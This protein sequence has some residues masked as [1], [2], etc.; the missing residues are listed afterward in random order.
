MK[1]YQYKPPYGVFVCTLF[2]L[3]LGI[4]TV[5][6]TA[7]TVR[8]AQRTD[9]AGES[10][11]DDPA[12]SDPAL[13]RYPEETAEDTTE[14]VS[15]AEQTEALERRA[16]EQTHD[17]PTSVAVILG[18]HVQES[19]AGRVKVVDVAAASP[20]FDAGIREGDEIIAFDGFKGKTY[21]EW[22]DGIRKLVTDTPDGE[23][24]AIDLVRG[25]KRVAA[26][27]RTPEAR[28]DDPRVPGLLGQQ[29][30]NEGQQGLAQPLSGNQPFAP[31][32]ISDND[33]FINDGGLFGDDSGAV[34]TE[35]AMAQI[36][37]L[38]PPQTTPLNPSAQQ[39]AAAGAGN[40][41]GRQTARN[42]AGDPQTPVAPGNP[43]VA[44]AARIGL[45]G[46][47]DDQNG[48]LVMID[49]GGLAP[50]SYPVGIEDPGLILGHRPMR[51]AQNNAAP[52]TD[53]VPTQDRTDRITRPDNN[54]PTIDQPRNN[55]PV[56]NR[57]TNVPRP[58]TRSQ[59][60]NVPD[61]V[62]RRQSAT[63]PDASE[64]IP[65][66]ILAQVT[67]DN[68][69]STGTAT[70]ATG[71]VQPT[72]TPATGQVNPPTTPPTGRVLPGGTPPTGRVLSPGAPA[73]GRVL[74]S[75]TTPTGQ[76]DPSAAGQGGLTQGGVNNDIASGNTLSGSS[77][78]SQIGVLTIDQSGTG[79]FQQIVE[80]A[81]VRDVVGQAIVI[82]APSN[83]PG[84]TVPPNT[85]VSG[86]RGDSRAFAGG[87][88]AAGNSQ[89]AAPARQPQGRTRQ[90]GASTA[91]LSGSPMPVAAGI[92]RPMSDRRP[93]SNAAV[94]TGATSDQD[95]PIQP[96][97]TT[98]PAAGAVTP[99][100]PSA[101]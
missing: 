16:G 50:G 3:L 55:R 81:R 72:A 58:G 43:A 61:R 30:P 84:T 85:S 95:Q 44:S 60:R 77:M 15:P 20:A 56:N 63:A 18:M 10:A 32:V 94:T 90:Q 45:A 2:M 11:S 13:T 71:Q 5:A 73:T 49:V 9:D 89:P 28:A 65:P 37:R 99:A 31:G 46:F 21:R 78:L 19:D 39:Q 70:P 92:I 54:R 53:R 12:D 69:A 26:Q 22:I 1:C 34:T 4:C 36:V 93:N 6:A 40:N 87:Q 24:V 98:Q 100:Q 47:R 66:T 68:A 79:R 35:R 7:Q 80:G 23:V 42:T 86:T 38:T 101:Q 97:Q 75:G 8:V 52:A 48:M 67:D 57:P 82:Y 76:P 33:V 62:D 64:L 29:L 88:P 17:D 96:Q 83:A 25:D 74:P 14:V 91:P 51:S 59:P 27:I 41:A